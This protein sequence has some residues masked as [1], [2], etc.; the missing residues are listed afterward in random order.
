MIHS[1]VSI[2]QTLEPKIKP[3]ALYNLIYN[4]NFIFLFHSILFSIQLWLIEV[5]IQRMRILVLFIHYIII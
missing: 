1:F 4:I 5:L 3:N 2:F